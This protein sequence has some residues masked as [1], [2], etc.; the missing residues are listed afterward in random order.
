MGAVEIQ[1][2]NRVLRGVQCK[3]S[4]HGA[5]GKSSASSCWTA[6]SG[7]SWHTVKPIPLYP[8]VSCC[9]RE[10]EHLCWHSLSEARS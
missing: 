8:S 10:H 1:K 3:L 4:E 9:L 2:G 6:A 7:Q 5:R